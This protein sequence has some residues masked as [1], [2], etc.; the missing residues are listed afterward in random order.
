MIKSFYYSAQ[1]YNYIDNNFNKAGGLLGEIFNLNLDEIVNYYTHFENQP[2]EKD[3]KI[4]ILLTRDL[5]YMLE[6]Y[7]YIKLMSFIL[8]KQNDAEKLLILNKKI[9]KVFLFC[10]VFIYT[11]IKAHFTSDFRYRREG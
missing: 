9:I 5:C 2:L 8:K 7:K 6:K 11:K 1:M 4:S 10:F 3:F